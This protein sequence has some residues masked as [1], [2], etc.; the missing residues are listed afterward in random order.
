MYQ[1]GN[2]GNRQCVIGMEDIYKAMMNKLE[3]GTMLQA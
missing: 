3:L 2:S 1:Q